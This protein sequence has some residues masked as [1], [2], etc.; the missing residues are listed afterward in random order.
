MYC[1]VAIYEHILSVQVRYKE[2]TVLVLGTYEYVYCI[3]VRTGTGITYIL[4]TVH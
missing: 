4:Y 2:Y 1:T 3:P